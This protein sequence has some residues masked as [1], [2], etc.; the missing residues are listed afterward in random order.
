MSWGDFETAGSLLHHRRSPSAATESE[1]QHHPIHDLLLRLRSHPFPDPRD[2]YWRDLLLHYGILAHLRS[3][4]PLVLVE[5]GRD[6]DAFINWI[7]LCG[8]VARMSSECAR[9]QSTVR[10][11]VSSTSSTVIRMT[12]DDESHHDDV[13]LLRTIE[14]RGRAACGAA[15]LCGIWAHDIASR[16]EDIVILSGGGMRK[17]LEEMVRA[18]VDLISVPDPLPQL[19]DMACESISLLIILLSPQLYRPI[20]SSLP[21]SDHN[22]ILS[23]LMSYESDR[24]QSLILSLLSNFRTNKVAPIESN[25]H[26]LR[27]PPVSRFR[28]LFEKSEEP[29]VPSQ[30]HNSTHKSVVRVGLN[31]ALAILSLPL[32]MVSYAMSV[33]GGIIMLGGQRDRPHVLPITAVDNKEDHL[34]L[35][36]RIFSLRSAHSLSEA[37]GDEIL[38]SVK[39]GGSSALVD[40]GLSFFFLLL[41]NYRQGQSN[42][43]RDALAN[44]KDLR[45]FDDEE[46]EEEAEEFLEEVDLNGPSFS[47]P[48]LLPPRRMDTA[49]S[50]ISVSSTSDAD[51]EK[52]FN[53]LCTA[54]QLESGILL[55]YTVLTS[56]KAFATYLSVRS[57]LD[58]ILLPLL[59]T[60]YEKSTMHTPSKRDNTTVRTR[61]S[62]Y[63]PPI[64]LLMVSQDPSF[65]SDAFRRSIVSFVPWYVERQ[66][67]N[68][69]LG[70]LM[71]LIL[72]RSISHNLNCIRDKYLLDNC[73]GV[74][75]NLV[76]EAHR[77]MH[78]YTAARLIDVMISCMK[79]CWKFQN[80]KDNLVETS[81][82]DMFV[83]VRV[84]CIGFPRLNQSYFFKLYVTNLYRRQV[85]HSCTVSIFAFAQITL[86]KV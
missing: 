71:I 28:L 5:G 41:H 75:W 23:L 73:C 66:L 34:S 9:M 58:I 8:H 27:F 15:R 85:G 44:L 55:L 19:F 49:Q 51:F 6:E 16:G 17:E 72:L 63:V 60:L 52:L 78:P 86:R 11:R 56:S 70:S 35:M 39:N 68:I 12:K 32:W 31:T 76:P 7:V 26:S 3:M 62:L 64:L 33:F 38:D 53:S 45:W 25:A 18:L 54:V 67:C 4:P 24:A 79:R 74:L 42:P 81:V 82:R 59:K 20:K 40:L 57:D 36:P 14:G 1:K 2:P 30:H 43:Y 37:N 84:F 21:N 80:E 29:F 77:G 10:P 50:H 47:T 22:V 65:G 83:E 13:S 48:T 46:E 69:S 61:S